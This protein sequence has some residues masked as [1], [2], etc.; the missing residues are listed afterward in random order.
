MESKFL[1]RIVFLIG[2]DQTKEIFMC[3][4]QLPFM[5]FQVSIMPLTREISKI[6]NVKFFKPLRA[7]F[8][9]SS[10]SGKTHLI[11]KILESQSKLFDDDFVSVKYFYPSYLE[12]SPV[13]YHSITNTPISYLEGFPQKS[14]VLS[15]SENSLLI[16]DDQADQA[17][18]S[19]LISQLF[20]VIS[21]KK[22]IS[23]ILVTQNYFIQGK[24]SRDI[25]NS[26]NYVALFR[27][28]CDYLLNKR[29]CTA[30]GLKDAY[31]AAEKE[32]YQTQVYPYI[33][34]DQTQRAQLSNYRLY[35]D[36][37]NKFKIAFSSTGMKGYILPEDQFLTKFKIISENK[38]KVIAVE[39]NEDKKR[40]ISKSSTTHDPTKKTKNN[41]TNRKRDRYN[42]TA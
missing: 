11:G 9:G 39:K 2:Y 6:N 8:S 34:I 33:F 37:L 32:I 38:E 36:I 30:F 40:K 18:K 42:D 19:D 13:N 41:K 5:S 21:G 16:I 29:V 28:C 1:K 26:C 4:Q 14:D 3:K 20:K 17:V 10:Q 27:N 35:V 7:I 31:L 23:V 12:E 25:R 24:H 22:N 15:M